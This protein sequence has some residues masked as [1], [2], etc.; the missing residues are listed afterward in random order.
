MNSISRVFKH[1]LFEKTVD[2]LQEMIKPGVRKKLP[3]IVAFIISVI[4]GGIKTGTMDAVNAIL[5]FIRYE[6]GLKQSLK[7]IGI[8]YEEVQKRCLDQTD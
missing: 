5:D 3:P 8:E 6:E 2:E 4:L 1:L 7:I